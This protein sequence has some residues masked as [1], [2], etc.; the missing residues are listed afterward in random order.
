MQLAITNYGGRIVSWLAP[1]SN[2]SFDDIVLGFDSIEGYLNANEAHYGALIG[3]CGNRIDKG[4]F[5]LNGTQYSLPKNGG[6]NHLHGGPRGFHN[7]V[8]DANQLN[9]QQ[10][11]L[12]Y[13]SEHGEEGYPGRLH[14]EVKYTLI[15][16]N[17]LKIDYTAKTNKS[18]VINL[19]SHPFFNLGGVG[20][21]KIDDHI[22]MINADCY[23]P[24]DS[25]LIP[26]GEIAPVKNTPFNFT[27]PT[28]IGERLRAENVQLRNGQGYDHNFVL[29][30][31]GNESPPLAARVQEPRSGRSL[32]VYTTE[33]GLQ[34][35]SGNA[36]DGS[37][38]GK[39]DKAYK[40]RTAFALEPQHF[41]DSPN[42]P[43]FPSTI[44]NPDDIYK[45]TTVFKLSA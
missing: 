1:D 4:R 32:E 22:L 34:F 12:S 29:N 37:D 33:P 45:S 9:E 42:Q 38:I 6:Q 14:V 43:N 19:T 13:I 11:L 23:T 27:K 17:G 36:L 10:L 16:K 39:G 2:G 7:V 25:G 8:W 24:V 40:H 26:T 15:N 3:R 44:L 20:S 18:T 30:K 41:P 35:Y 21:G 5:S 28:P 31:E